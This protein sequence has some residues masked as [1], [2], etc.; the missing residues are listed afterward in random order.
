MSSFP[1]RTTKARLR[2]TLVCARFYNAISRRTSR[3]RDI[4]IKLKPD[5]FSIY[6]K[7]SKDRFLCC[8]A[9]VINYK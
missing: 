9:P 1:C 8:V 2:V 7:L 3:R 5:L 4:G 6:Q